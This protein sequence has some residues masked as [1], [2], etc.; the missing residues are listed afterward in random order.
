M[1]A[2]ASPPKKQPTQP[3]KQSVK[4]RGNEYLVSKAHNPVARSRRKHKS[5][6]EKILEQVKQYPILIASCIVVIILAIVY[7]AYA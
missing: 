6:V 2:P 3:K 1:K 5:E 7:A 4:T